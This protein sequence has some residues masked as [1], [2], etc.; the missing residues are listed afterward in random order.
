MNSASYC[1][2]YLRIWFLLLL[3]AVSAAVN[4]EKVV[5]DAHLQLESEL[6]NFASVECGPFAIIWSLFEKFAC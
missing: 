3:V 5:V 1:L 4:A 2:T 6:N